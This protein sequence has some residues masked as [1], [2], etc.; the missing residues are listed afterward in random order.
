HPQRGRDGRRADRGQGGKGECLPSA[1]A[2]PGQEEAAG[3]AESRERGPGEEREERVAHAS[4]EVARDRS[5]PPLPPTRIPGQRG[6]QGDGRGQAQR[7]AEAASRSGEAKGERD[8][9]Q[10]H[11]DA[12]EDVYA[13]EVGGPAEAAT[14]EHSYAEEERIAED[15]EG[16]AE[17][18]PP[19]VSVSPALGALPFRDQR[20]GQAGQEE[21]QRSRVAAEETGQ[22]E[23]AGA[24]ILRHRPGG[25]RVGVDHEEDGQATCPVQVSEARRAPGASVA[26]AR[27][28]GHNPGLEAAPLTIPS[29]VSDG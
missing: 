13:Q 17:S 11:R 24:A 7:R 27:K 10:R 28:T 16:A 5:R 21:E 15:G 23:E 29:L 20:R 22:G 18:A 25:E 2:I 9:H 4:R 19:D 14:R 8:Q 6:Q 1:G 26:W 3:R 12:V